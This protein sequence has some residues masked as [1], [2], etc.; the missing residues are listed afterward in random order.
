MAIIPVQKLIRPITREEVMEDLIVLG[1]SLKLRTSSWRG[2]AR[3]L[4]I[5]LA[6]IG[7]RCTVQIAAIATFSYNDTAWG[8]GLTRLS[9]SQFDNQRLTGSRAR[10]LLRAADTG[11]VGP[12]TWPARTRTFSPS[13][14]Y[15]DLKFTNINAE[16]IGSGASN[17]AIEVEALAAGS[18]YNNVPN[19][20]TWN[21]N[22]V[23]AGITITNPENDTGPADNWITLLGT[24]QEAATQLR[25]RNTSKWATLGGNAPIGAYEFWALNAKDSNGDPVGITRVTIPEPLG[26]GAMTVYCATA[27]GVPDGAQISATQAYINARKARTATPTVTAASTQ[28]VTVTATI[29]VKSGSIITP[30]LASGAANGVINDTPIGGREDGGTGVLVRDEMLWAIRE[31]DPNNV[32]KIAMSVPSADV[33]LPSN[34]IAVG[35]SHAFTVVTI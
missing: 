4:L 33:D 35:G 17:V 18:A 5:A 16:T 25:A 31:L 10:G 2:P 9:D 7:S 22:P 32:V 34:T 20:V 12:V 11:A 3:W 15:A 13:G 8:H 1:D 29:T 14:Q 24:D 23:Q 27:S 6:E 21:A 19:D 26:S 28:T 30:T